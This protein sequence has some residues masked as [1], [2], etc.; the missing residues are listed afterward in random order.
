MEVGGLEVAKKP[1]HPH[2]ILL[3]DLPTFLE[4]D[5][6]KTIRT[7]SF[8]TRHVVDC[9]EHLPLGEGLAEGTKVR[10]LEIKRLPIEVIDPAVPFSHC[11]FEIVMHNACFLLKLGHPP[12]VMLDPMNMILSPSCIHSQMEKF[13]VG[14]ALFNVCNPR[15]L[16]IRIF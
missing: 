8:V 10:F 13:R 3:D 1:N 2:Q 6:D 12:I 4:E 15:T 11:H 14:V 9:V 7:G 5:T 16:F